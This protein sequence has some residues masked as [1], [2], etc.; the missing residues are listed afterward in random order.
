MNYLELA[1]DFE[2]GERQRKAVC[3]RIGVH[4]SVSYDEVPNPAMETM[5]SALK[6]GQL[7]P[8]EI[9]VRSVFEATVTDRMG[10][11]CGREMVNSWRDTKE[12]RVTGHRI[13]ESGVRS[14]AFANIMGQ[15]FYTRMMEEFNKPELI[16]MS[17]VELIPSSHQWEKIA[18]VSMLGD[19]AQEVKEGHDYP[20]VSLAEDWVMSPETKKYGFIVP[21]TREAIFFDMTGMVLRRAGETAQILAVNREKRILDTVCGIVHSYRRKNRPVIATYGD[22][23]GD[24]DFDN[25]AAS[26]AL[27]DCDSLIAAHQLFQSMTDPHDG[28]PI[29]LGKTQLVC[30]KPLEWK[31][32][33]ILNATEVREVSESGARETIVQ[34]NRLPRDYEIRSNEYVQA[35]TGS[36]S[37]WFYGDFPG[38]F[39]YVENWAPE[40][41][42]APTG[43]HL[44]MTRDIAAQFKISERGVMAVKEPRKVVKSTGG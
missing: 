9:S 2:V 35:R 16:G 29:V 33:A 25:L 10:K 8:E 4:E 32:R 20:T 5:K 13:Y 43:S 39:A 28:E 17:L 37:T 24:H 15:V 14:A 6:S 11:R 38:A 34:G 19:H 30:P 18:G 26:N 21:V 36:A 40:A 31:A 12:G 22:A 1:H 42:E 7:K 3:R 44:E 41:V 23:S 27:V